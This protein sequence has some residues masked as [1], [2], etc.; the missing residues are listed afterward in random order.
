MKKVKA[1]KKV[2]GGDK[3]QTPPTESNPTRQHYQQAG[4]TKNGQ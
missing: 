2:K 3:G 1:G 4:G